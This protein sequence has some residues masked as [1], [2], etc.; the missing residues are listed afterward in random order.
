MIIYRLHSGIYTTREC[1]R[2]LMTR[3]VRGHP[4]LEISGLNIRLPVL[5]EGPQV[6][7][8]LHFA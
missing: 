8:R 6:L 3:D 7:K 5:S 2:T 1:Q 4:W